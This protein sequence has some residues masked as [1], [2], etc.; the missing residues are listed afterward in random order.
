MQKPFNTREL[1]ARVRAVQRRTHTGNEAPCFQINELAVDVAAHTVRVSGAE[2]RLTP[3]E[4]ALLKILSH[5]AG[6][7]VTS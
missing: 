3:I 6:K 2:V 5:H 4:F 1:L 7:V